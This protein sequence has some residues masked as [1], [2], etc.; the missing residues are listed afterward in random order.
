MGALIAGALNGAS[1]NELLSAHYS[2]VADYWEKHPL[3]HE[4]DEIAR[5]SFR[6]REPPEIAGTGYVVRS[7]EAAL[8]A[9]SRSD[10]FREGC[11]LA[12]NLGDDA[13]TTGAI[14]GQLAGTFYGDNAIPQS[15][16]EKLAH[17]PL[18][19]SFADQIFNLAAA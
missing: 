5:G 1:E 2:P 13:D 12:V 4:I 15:W 8:W 14:F 16:R 9:F 10:S 7:L 3:C 11:L 18:I 6:R 17:R 19:E